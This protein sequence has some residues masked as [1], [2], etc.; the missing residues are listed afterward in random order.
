M[1]ESDECALERSVRVIVHSHRE[2]SAVS[3]GISVRGVSGAAR[4]KR[5]AEDQNR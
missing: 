4:A 2:Y 1:V 3:M 5:R